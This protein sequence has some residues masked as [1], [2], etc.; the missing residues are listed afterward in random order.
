MA[1]YTGTVI[2]SDE[3]G[4]PFLAII[5]NENGDLVGSYPVRTRTDGE[6]AVAEALKELAEKDKG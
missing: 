1:S 6:A 4:F 2:D 3:D 5:T